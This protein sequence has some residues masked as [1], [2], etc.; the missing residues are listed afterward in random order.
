VFA[1]R[2]RLLVLLI[3]LGVGVPVVALA[4]FLALRDDPPADPPAAL[5]M[6][7]LAGT[8]APDDTKLDDCRAGSDEARCLEQAFGNLSYNEG[9]KAALARFDRLRAKPGTAESNCH[10]IAHSIGSAALARYDGDV[11]RAFAEGSASCWSGYYHGILERAL[12]GADTD[13]ELTSAVRGI[14]GEILATATRYVSYQCVHGLGHGLMIR[15]GLHLERALDG[16]EG[17][18]TEWEQT[19][20]DGGVFMENFSSS[21]GVKSRWLRD[22]DLLY[23]CNAVAEKHKLYCYLQIT[24][25]LLSGT[26]WDWEKTAEECARAETAWRATCFQSFG[27]SASGISRGNTAELVRLCS[28]PRGDDRADCVYGAARDRVSND[29]G[30]GRA[31]AFCGQAPARAR[32]FEGIGTILVTLAPD[33]GRTRTACAEAAP[34]AAD[35]AACLRGAG[36]AA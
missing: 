26:G 5:E 3:A 11:G 2:R 31:A 25:R 4:G 1:S 32:C 19:S 13:A 15:T 18:R 28:I 12:V 8:F 6:H 33:A 23:P 17:L 29:A 27:R 22:D 35:R 9:P 36:I 34:A 14:C 20:C 21:Y 7:P 16:C 24:D 10:R 30:A